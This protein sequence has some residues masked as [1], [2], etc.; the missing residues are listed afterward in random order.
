MRFSYRRP[1]TH[2]KGDITAIR[3]D[4][5]RRQYKR[6]YKR[7]SFAHTTCV[8]GPLTLS[9][10]SAAMLSGPRLQLARFT[11]ETPTL[12]FNTAVSACHSLAQARMQTYELSV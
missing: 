8:I 12:H 5:L 6:C 9:R 10:R 1:S 7:M 11:A 4:M 3:V 2:D